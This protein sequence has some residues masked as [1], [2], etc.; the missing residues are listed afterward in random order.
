MEVLKKYKNLLLF[1]LKLNLVVLIFITFASY[2]GVPL[3]DVKG[4]FYYAL[5]LIILQ[6]SA[7]G[8]IY[9]FTL[10]KFIFRF[11]FSTIFIFYSFIAFWNYSL[12]I[13]FSD[14]ILDATLQTQP[15]IAI[16][17]FSWQLFI[18]VTW[19]F[20]TLYYLQKEYNK[21]YK[22][23]FS[24]LFLVLS[25]S[26]IGLYFLIEHQRYGT[27][28]SRLPFNVVYETYSYLSKPIIETQA[29]HFKVS[30]KQNNLKVYLV[31]GE[32][33]RADHLGLNGYKR[34]TTPNLKKLKNLISFKNAY[35]ELTYTGISLPQILTNQS[36]YGTKITPNY[37][38]IDLMNAANITTHW[39]GNQTPE[40]SYLTFITACT[41][42]KLIDPLRSSHSFI[43]KSD[44][45][46]L[47][48]KR[49]Y[50]QKNELI[51]YHMIGSHWYY[52]GKYLDKFRTFKP[53]ITSK[54]LPSNTSEEIINSYDNTILQLDYF[55]F[56]LISKIEQE[57]ENS[58]LIYVSDHGELL[59]EN[60]KW[61]H[62]TEGNEYAQKNP[63]MMVWFSKDYLSGNK[64]QYEKS[65]LKTNSKLP[66]DV[67][68]H[69][70]L[71]S[72]EIEGSYYNPKLSVFQ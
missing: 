5:H 8:F 63:A 11:I 71:N 52:E 19:S 49:P 10:N 53:V 12:G 45:E 62:A 31:L 57:N 9:F 28:K 13:S 50:S 4:Y 20:V 15:D 14:G 68:F 37:S 55:L 46:L 43:K 60:G 32:S 22:Q 48:I 66:L 23:R 61:L 30:S 26:F 54:H 40:K 33:V 72:F 7:F 35:T 59:G 70:V 51:V 69:T 18:Y 6:V 39:Y 38:L 64:I 34:N 29:I 1:Y 67:I 36:I 16:D 41:N 58:I 56:Q 27:L 2:Y 42:K 24:K 17:L 21:I 25:I 65:L 44:V 47:N 3:S